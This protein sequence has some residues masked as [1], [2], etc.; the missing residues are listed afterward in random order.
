MG[1]WVH[2][3]ECT[4][5]AKNLASLGKNNKGNSGLTDAYIT[6]NKALDTAKEYVG[7]NYSTVVDR[8]GYTRYISEDGKYVAR[9]GYKQGNQQYELNLEIWENGIVI[10]NYHMVVK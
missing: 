6:K 1:I 9:Y 7:K 3:T 2:N 5:S 10:S 8:N 4:V